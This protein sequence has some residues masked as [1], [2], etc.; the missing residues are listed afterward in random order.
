M[1][2]ASSRTQRVTNFGDWGR[3][4]RPLVTLFGPRHLPQ[5]DSRRPFRRREQNKPIVQ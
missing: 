1:P 2:L 4:D 5:I 3:M